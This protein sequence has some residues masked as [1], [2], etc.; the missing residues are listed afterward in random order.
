[1]SIRADEIK[2]WINCFADDEMIAIDEAGMTLVSR[3]LDDELVIGGIPDDEDWDNA[4]N[5]E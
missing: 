5:A 1:M 4:N 2:T 3:G